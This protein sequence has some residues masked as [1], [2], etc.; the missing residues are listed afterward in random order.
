LASGVKPPFYLREQSSSLL[1][2]QKLTLGRVGGWGDAIIKRW[3]E[4]LLPITILFFLPIS[5]QRVVLQG[6][7]RVTLMLVR[8]VEEVAGEIWDYLEG[9]WRACLLSNIWRQRK[10]LSRKW[11]SGGGIN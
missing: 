11:K 8:E 1:G 2:N 7:G 4:G 10:Q 6:I 3:A 9:F 5:K